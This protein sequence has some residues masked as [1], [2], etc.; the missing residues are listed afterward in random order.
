MVELVRAPGFS[1]GGDWVDIDRDWILQRI[2]DYKEFG[3]RGYR[4]PI[5][6]EHDTEKGEREG[7]VGELLLEQV[8]GVDCLC[9][10]LDFFDAADAEKMRN[11]RTKYVSVGLGSVITDTDQRFND[12]V[13]EVS[14]VSMPHAMTAS[15]H[16]LR[17]ASGRV[18]LRGQ[19]M[20]KDAEGRE[21][22]DPNYSGPAERNVDSEGSGE[23]VRLGEER[24]DSALA[25]M[26]EGMESL[27]ERMTKMEERMAGG[28]KK[29]EEPVEREA[30]GGDEDPEREEMKREIA[31]LRRKD[32]E[33]TFMEAF[34]AVGQVKVTAKLQRALFDVMVVNEGLGEKLVAAM[35]EAHSSAPAAVDAGPPVINHGDLYRHS[36]NQDAGAS[37][38]EGGIDFKNF[39]LVDEQAYYERT[40]KEC[41]GD[42]VKA[43][44]KMAEIYND[45]RYH[46]C[47][48]ARG[49]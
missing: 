1:Y 19:D 10:R 3:S 35:K 44:E 20:P 38:S 18:V 49:N 21:P 31:R 37:K 47:A 24:I 34:P 6:I 29:K 12:L 41:G 2:A 45:P 14:L 33:R 22:S 32:L 16:V 4:S 48:A 42:R 43:D 39:T 17:S 25:R 46:E 7:D 26:V 5:L 13:L 8:E 27:S 28:D 40:V 9:A 15:T 11:G 36:W 23:G 30:E